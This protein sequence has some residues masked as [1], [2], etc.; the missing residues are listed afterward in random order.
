MTHSIGPRD[1]NEPEVIRTLE[2]VGAMVIKMRTPVD[3]L[4]GFR[5][6]NYLLEVKRPLGRRK[7]GSDYTPD[8]RLF[9]RDWHG[10][11]HVVRTP[12]EA[13]LAIGA[14]ADLQSG[15]LH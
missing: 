4:V 13:L 3:L 8:Q 11:V 15:A 5:G 2:Q 1:A 10:S 12:N 14:I 9:F 6:Y 7:R